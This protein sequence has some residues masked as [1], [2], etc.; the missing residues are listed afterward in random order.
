MALLETDYLF[1]EDPTL[2]AHVFVFILI[3]I[4][5]ILIFYVLKWVFSGFKK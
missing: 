2:A 1:G 4:P 3:F 5:L